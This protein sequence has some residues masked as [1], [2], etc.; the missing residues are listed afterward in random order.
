MDILTSNCMLLLIFAA[1]RVTDDFTFASWVICLVAA[2]AASR[3]TNFCLRSC[4]LPRIAIFDV[5]PANLQVLDPLSP[6][7]RGCLSTICSCAI[8]EEDNNERK[9][10]ALRTILIA[11]CQNGIS[12]SQHDCYTQDE[13]CWIWL[14]VA[15]S[16]HHPTI[17]NKSVWCRLFV[18]RD[19]LQ[20]KT[21]G[22][23]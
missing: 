16:S 11:S 21:A 22:I 17:C 18:D 10:E 3:W 9:W 6:G 14:Q 2:L 19:I 8:A 23:A 20:C 1:S 4:C 13:S 5:G 12:S 15:G 7:G